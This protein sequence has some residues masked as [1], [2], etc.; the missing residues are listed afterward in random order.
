MARLS[1][2]GRR[3]AN[4]EAWAAATRA[5]GGD[6]EV[7]DAIWRA[8]AKQQ[9]AASEQPVTQCGVPAQE[10]RQASRLREA[11]AQRRA[12]LSAA[13]YVP[14]RRQKEAGLARLE[15]ELAALEAAHG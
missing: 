11:I 5:A 10:S 7:R 12:E 4:R 6:T 8:R 9:A 15:A 3:A 14:Y 2:E 1:K 13:C